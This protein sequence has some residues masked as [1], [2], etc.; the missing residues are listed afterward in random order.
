M[1][2]HIRCSSLDQILGC[3]GSR[4]L[5]AALGCERTDE[6]EAWDGIWV[7]AETARRLVN[8]HGAVPPPTGLPPTRLPEN[9]VPPPFMRWM[10]DYLV[11]RVMEHAGADRAI[12]V[13]SELSCEFEDFIL[14]G[15][16][17]V[18]TI[19]ADATELCFDDYKA[20]INVVDQADQNWQTAGYA[21]LFVLQ[22]PT[23]KKITGRIIQPRLAAE[24][25]ISE[26]VLEGEQLAGIVSFLEGRIKQ[27]LAN[28]MLLETGQKQCR[29]CPAATRCPALEAEENEMKI[30][31]TKESLAALVAEP[32]PQALARVAI[33]KKLLEPRFKTA[34][35]ALKDYMETHPGEIVT[36]DGTVLTLKDR[37]GQREITDKQA[38]FHKLAGHY[39][40]GERTPGSGGSTLTFVPGLLDESAVLECVKFSIPALEEKAA[41]A[42]SLPLDSKKGDS[43][44]G[45]ITEAL[46]GLVQQPTQRVLSIVSP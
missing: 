14:T 13:E 44:K 34:S 1:K 18:S 10:P 26:M 21:A 27:A 24:E 46:A 11:Q 37:A 39:E 41:E 19:D 9:Y 3:P 31:L 38:A 7:H 42:L 17:D 12:E 43:G 28:P 6:A 2:P 30:T 8:A 15:H 25:R 35:E 36:P 29:W 5:V 22:W 33:A 20:G 23:L 4:T 45:R 32:E 40:E 16:C